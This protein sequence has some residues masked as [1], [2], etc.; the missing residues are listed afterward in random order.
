MSA[1]SGDGSF[2][3]N[4]NENKSESNIISRVSL[5]F[6]INLNKRDTKVLEG[7]VGYFNTVRL[8]NV[9]HKIKRQ[10]HTKTQYVYTSNNT[11]T[12]VI[13]NIDEIN[14]IIIPFFE[15]YPVQGLKSLEFA[16]F[17][18]I[19]KMIICKDHLTVEGLNKILEIRK[20]M[21]KHRKWK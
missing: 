14:D 15:S 12:F 2:H 17:K 10:L 7:L 21:N 1:T 19:A 11:V 20:N 3:L 9:E 18:Q 5:R 6:S 13:S 4:I 8:S 16:D